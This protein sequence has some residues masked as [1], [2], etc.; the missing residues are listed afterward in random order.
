MLVPSIIFIFVYFK[1]K[2]EFVVLARTC[3]PFV[4]SL[5]FIDYA[6][7]T[8]TLFRNLTMLSF[9][10]A[11]SIIWIHELVSLFN[12]SAMTINKLN[13]LSRVMQP[14]QPKHMDVLT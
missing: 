12:D 11:K 3:D 2:F 9:Y 6:I 1:Q 5:D 14:K 4:T 13:I 10:L 7:P 8:I